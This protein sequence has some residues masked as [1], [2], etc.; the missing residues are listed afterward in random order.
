MHEALLCL[1]I[2]TIEGRTIAQQ[3]LLILR[4]KVAVLVEPIGQMAGRVLICGAIRALIAISALG[5]ICGVAGRRAHSTVTL[6]LALIGPLLILIGPLILVLALL[7][8]EL[9]ILLILLADGL[10]LLSE[11]RPRR[12]RRLA[13]AARLKCR[14]TQE[15][16][17]SGNSR[18]THSFRVWNPV[19]RSY[20]RQP[21]TNSKRISLRLSW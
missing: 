2:E 5:A 6:R 16:D 11:T 17:C 4:G 19:H 20:S 7:I 21:A 15:Q 14:Q 18:R 3:P 9:P 12:R 1:W 10:T 13:L 8:L